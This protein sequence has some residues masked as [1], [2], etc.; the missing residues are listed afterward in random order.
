[1][2]LQLQ[3][4]FTKFP[5]LKEFGLLCLS[6]LII[7]GCCDELCDNEPE[8][9]DS[10]DLCQ[11][12]KEAEDNRVIHFSGYCWQV[13]NDDGGPGC[14]YFSDSEDV[15]WKDDD[16]N[17]HLKIKKIDGEWHCASLETLEHLGYG[18]YNVEV[19]SDLSTLDKNVV[20]GMSLYEYVKYSLP[21]E[22]DIEVTA[23][24]EEKNSRKDSMID[25]TIFKSHPNPD[26]SDDDR[27]G[28]KPTQRYDPYYK[29]Q[30]P[31]NQQTFSIRW[32][33]D[34]VFFKTNNGKD[35]A[36]FKYWSA[37]PGEFIPN[38]SEE[39]FNLNLWLNDKDDSDDTDE[40][41]CGC[42][43]KRGVGDPPS[44]GQPQ[45]VVIKSFDFVP[46]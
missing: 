42:S 44:D 43:N 13:S 9:D 40:N 46:N 41:C 25:Y 19:V 5:S 1:M 45:E 35:Y 17:L 39:K 22:I 24:G 37:D 36:E 30:N 21:D 10:K 28:Y 38:A 23:W 4:R 7:T 18:T 2:G 14:N 11:D 26:P 20:F 12:R 3:N 27:E 31:S 15:V 16:D 6:M 8:E 33:S 29:L 32:T 34:T